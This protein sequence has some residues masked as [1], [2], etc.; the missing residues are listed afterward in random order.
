MTTTRA[1][2]LL[3][4]IALGSWTAYADPITISGTA[5]GGLRYV[6]DPGDSQ[7]VAGSTDVA[8]LVTP[9]AGLNGDAPA[10]M[11]KAP[12]VGL[13]SLGD[14]DGFSASYAL[15]GDSTGPDQ[16][17]W[18][19][20]LDAPGGGYIGVVSFSGPNLDASTDI[21]V[22]YDYATDP[23][24]S[25]TYWGETLGQLD[26]T[27]YGSTTFGQ[28]TVYETGVEIGDWDVSDSLS[29]SANIASI[30]VNVGV[31][32]RSSTFLLLGLGL[33]ALG[34]LGFGQK[35]RQAAE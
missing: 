19:T 23:L 35:R 33:A 15:Y 14:L 30:T 12:N 22:F 24:S 29:A 26:S 7:Y 32:D 1:A 21:H 20:Y 13:A 4:F 6:G 25:N 11:I 28:M 9:D 31:P 27:V 17:Y 18:L 8:Q 10:V 3:S 5:L 34:V 16:P 2:L